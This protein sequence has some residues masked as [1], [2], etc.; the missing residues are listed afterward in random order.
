[1]KSVARRGVSPGFELARVLVVDADPAARLTLQTV[2]K[3]CGYH[4]D[5]AASAAEAITKLEEG[6][7][8]LVLSDLEVES[9][10]AGLKVMAHAR[11]TNYK[12]ATALIHVDETVRRKLSSNA[13]SQ[14]L[15]ETEDIPE[16]LTK[17]ATLIGERAT[18]RVA[19]EM[20]SAGN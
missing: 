4:V 6:Q 8:A 11:M 9:P 17:V 7:Y 13:S 20:R 2:L 3:A 18:R 10:E 15:I 14:V 1:M 16:L 5:A 19:R 12:P